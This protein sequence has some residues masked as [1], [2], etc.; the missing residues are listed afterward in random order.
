MGNSSMSKFKQMACSGKSAGDIIDSD[1]GNIIWFFLVVYHHQ[2]QPL[3]VTSNK[4]ASKFAGINGKEP[5]NHPQSQDAVQH[6]RMVALGKIDIVEHHFIWRLFKKLSNSM[7][8]LSNRGP[9]K[10]RSQQA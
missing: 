6:F 7:Q 10:G 1:P 2:G 4:L 5:R 9:G 3:P 8:N